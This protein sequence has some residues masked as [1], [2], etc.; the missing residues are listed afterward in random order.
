MITR[1]Q[2]TDY[3]AKQRQTWNINNIRSTTLGRSVLERL[4]NY[5]R[6]ALKY[7]YV[8]TVHGKPQQ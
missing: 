1:L 6:L 2:G 4:N 5:I 7:H 3:T 8:D